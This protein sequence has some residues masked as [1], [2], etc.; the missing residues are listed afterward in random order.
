MLHLRATKGQAKNK[1]PKYQLGEI[2]CLLEL[3]QEKIPISGDNC[4][5][6]ARKNYLQYPD[7]ERN[8]DSL[9]LKFYSLAKTKTKTDD[10]TIPPAVAKAN[11][12]MVNHTGNGCFNRVS[13]FV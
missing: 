2:D 9:K 7:K 12:F 3:A 8:R 6:I 13:L 4:N 11:I 5:D 1:G 10:P